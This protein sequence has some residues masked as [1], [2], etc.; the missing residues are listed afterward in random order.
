MSFSNLGLYDKVLAAVTATGNVY[1][2][3]DAWW[4]LEKVTAISCK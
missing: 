1:E 2:R 4:G 3:M